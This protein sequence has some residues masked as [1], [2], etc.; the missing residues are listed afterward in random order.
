MVNGKASLTNATIVL[1]CVEAKT[2]K[3][4]WEKPNVGK[5]HAALVKTGDNKLLF[6][7]DAGN[8]MLLEPNEK[9]YKELARANVCG[10]TWAHPALSNGKLYLRDDKKLICLQL[11]E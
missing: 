5:Y 8:L 10:E 3:I 11:G 4:L 9:Q 1:R 7:D 6:V 2:G